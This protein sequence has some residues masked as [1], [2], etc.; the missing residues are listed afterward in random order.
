MA[1]FWLDK[2]IELSNHL[3]TLRLVH[4]VKQVLSAY[5]QKKSTDHEIAGYSSCVVSF[6]F[7]V[8]TSE[9]YRFPVGFVVLSSCFCRKAQPT[10][11]LHALVAI[12]SSMWSMV[13][14]VRTS[15][16]VVI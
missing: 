9:R 14:L 15:S 6:R 16:S 10:R 2:S 3:R 1:Q 12:S 4:I 7:S 11:A 8:L 5:E 13:V